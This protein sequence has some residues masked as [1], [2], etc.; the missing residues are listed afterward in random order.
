MRVV[1]WNMGCAT[2][3]YCSVRDE[4][5]RFLLGLEPDIAL[6]QE[7]MLDLPAW[8]EAEGT[9]FI[10]PAFGD[11]RWGSAEPVNEFETRRG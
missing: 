8:L 2:K 5:W 1:S 4:A 3:R 7:A 6:V 9:L 11:Q 10:R